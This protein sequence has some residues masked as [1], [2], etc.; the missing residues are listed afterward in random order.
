MQQTSRPHTGVSEESKLSAIKTL[1]IIGFI[2]TTIILVWLAV[3]IVRFI[4]EGFSS[5]ASLMQSVSSPG[6]ELNIST[7]RTIVNVNDSVTVSWD[8]TGTKGV[9]GFSYSCA[10]GV[11]G[12]MLLGGGSTALLACDS[13]V[14][15]RDDVTSTEFS[16]SSTQNRFADVKLAVRFTPE[17]GSMTGITESVMVTVVNDTIAEEGATP[18]IPETPAATTTPPVVPEPVKPVTPQPVAPSYPVSNPNGF[19]DLQIS[20]IGIGDY[21]A[22]TKVFTPKSS[23]DN[24]GRRALRFEVMNIGTKTSGT[25]SY[26]ATLPT[27]G[28]DVYRAGTQ[29]ALL[30]GERS[31]ITVL[32]TPR[33]KTGTVQIKAEVSGG[34]DTKS[35]NNDFTRSVSITN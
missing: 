33:E 21:N 19:T 17:N 4:P 27:E 32:F 35:A 3:M 34:N 20:Y 28:T 14:A 8:K 2:T 1:A 23:L 26:N 15:L 16:F 7:N 30:P 25:W 22:G 5:L 29:A 6:R 11:S 18:L 12:S 10:D 31:I 13:W 9:Y 24:D